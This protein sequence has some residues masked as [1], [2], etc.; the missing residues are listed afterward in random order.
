M[1]KATYE[2]MSIDELFEQ[3]CAV[4]IKADEAVDAGLPIEEQHKWM[5]IAHEI[6][7]ELRTRGEQVRPYYLKL[8]KSEHPTLRLVG[9]LH[10][11]KYAPELA[12]PVL[13][14]LNHGKWGGTIGMNASMT[15]NGMRRRGEIPA[16][17]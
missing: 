7:R 16:R 5:A 14:E 4:N 13:E 2:K 15:L 1:S 6:T 3:L 9:A 11:R 10:A 17:P 8:L 12:V